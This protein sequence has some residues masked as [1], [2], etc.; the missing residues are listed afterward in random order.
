MAFTFALS[1]G[2]FSSAGV[3]AGTRLLLTILSD[4]LDALPPEKAGCSASPEGA[5]FWQGQNVPRRI[6]DAGCGAGI[7]GVC[8]ARA[9]AEQD[10]GPAPALHV[11]AQD[12]DALAALFTA[13]NARRNGVASGAFSAHTEP[14]LAGPPESRWDL[15]LSNIPAKAGR[16]VLEDFV[17]RSL[18]L[19]APG[20]RVLLVAVNTLAAFFR[21]L[22]AGAG[23]RL[24]REAAGNGHT[25]FVYGS[26]AGEAAH[27]AGPGGAV[28][29]G[30][31]TH[32]GAGETA[33]G[34]VDNGDPGEAAGGDSHDAGPGDGV[35][36]GA[37]G[38]VEG[39]AVTHGAA[40][41]ADGGPPAGPVETG[42]D[43]LA[44]HPFY[45]RQR[46]RYRIEGTAYT[47][48]TVHGAPLFDDPGAAVLAAA[49]LFVRLKDRDCGAGPLLFHEC[50]QGHFPLW[51]LEYDKEQG[52]GV[53]AGGDGAGPAVTLSGRNIL[54]LEA[55]AHNIRLVLA[56]AP[57]SAPALR[58]IPAV[59]PAP[60]TV[61]PEGPA[62][63]FIAAF[64]ETV[65][66]TDRRAA[67]WEAFSRL[68]RPG[69]LL[70]VTLP[71]GEAEKFGRKKPAEFVR[72]GDLRR[73]GFRAL[74]CR[75]T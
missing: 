29:G 64:P 11:R 30:S 69:G 60:E 56:G 74:A 17:P 23:G 20:G 40:G 62:F 71:S 25:V 9:L 21:A 70:L 5:G 16:P 31:V 1:L 8:A 53:T 52:R 15:I 13:Y 50:A 42:A 54:S 14:L 51:F 59:E 38:S 22:I 24:L 44:R 41:A 2:L 66:R 47:L 55:A 36:Y 75:K 68:L 19:L 43:F 61:L 27:A 63:S 6:L 46:G 65:P 57:G 48:D 28:A 7:I 45:L 4:E 10:G 33:D 3:D 35:T 73:G 37:A 39:G 58:V 67:L 49:K 72:A 12:R 32:G 34:A 18:G 26:P